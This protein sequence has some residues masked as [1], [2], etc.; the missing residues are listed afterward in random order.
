MILLIIFIVFTMFLLYAW[1]CIIVHVNQYC[2]T[3]TSV[4]NMY[5][6]YLIHYLSIATSL[7]CSAQLRTVSSS[8][9]YGP[10]PQVLN[11][12][13]SQVPNVSIALTLSSLRSFALCGSLRSVLGPN[14]PCARWATDPGVGEATEQNPSLCDP[15]IITVQS[16]IALRLIWGS[17]DRLYA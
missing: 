14:Q 16:I 2:S 13:C 1:A 12:T 3:L 4:F 15:S 9:G 17:P 8:S 5:F 7:R 10:C 6:S 11:K